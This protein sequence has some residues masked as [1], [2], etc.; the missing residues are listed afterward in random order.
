MWRAF[1]GMFTREFIH[2]S[3]SPSAPQLKPEM[4]LLTREATQKARE[5]GSP[6]DME[7]AAS[8]WKLAA[9]AEKNW[10]EAST[11]RS[12][13]RQEGLKSWAQILVPLISILTLAATLLTQTMQQRA[14]QEAQED[15]AWRTAIANF[16]PRSGPQ[17]RIAGLMAQVQLKPFMRSARHKQE[18]TELA[19]LILPEIADPEIFAD[20]F[21][22]IEWHDLDEMVRVNRSLL[23]LL[24]ESDDHLKRLSQAAGEPAP[25][26]VPAGFDPSMQRIP[27]STFPGLKGPT[28]KELME[29]QRDEIF[30][31]VTF[32]CDKM[33]AASR[34]R[35][36]RTEK[37]DL[38]NTYFYNC[39]LSQVHWDGAILSN[40]GFVSV[41]LKGAHFSNVTAIEGSSWDNS[42]WWDAEEISQPLL[43]K[44]MDEYYP[45]SDND[46]APVHAPTKAQYIESLRQLCQTAGLSCEGSPIKFV[47]IST[48]P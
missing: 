48:N 32:V 23:H 17:T 9:E 37:L 44:L 21:N 34:A 7:H 35:T 41:N 31:T 29:S 26:G 43:K 2:S 28:I 47:E 6:S 18:A 10:A 13:L 11:Q 36:L 4:E 30:Q 24:N 33:A 15:T 39:D 22:A 3:N 20:L 27:D 38:N 14:T 16:S 45:G 19:R 46:K 42:D 40:S 5:S 25:R 12:N 8:V 1:W